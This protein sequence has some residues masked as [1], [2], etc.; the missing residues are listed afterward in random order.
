MK[1]SPMMQQYM[2]IKDA[3][4]DCILFFR[5]GDFY[6]MF[7]EDAILVSRLLDLTLTG[8]SCG[9]EDRAPM[10]GVPYHA[11][12][13]Y[14]GKLVDAGHRVAVCEQVEDPALAKGLVRREVVQVITPGTIPSGVMLNDGENNYLASLYS[15]D[16]GVGFSY[17]DISTGE[18]RTTFFEGGKNLETLIDEVARLGIRELLYPGAGNVSMELPE[19]ILNSVSCITPL[20]GH[21]YHHEKNASLLVEH[22]MCGSLTSL[23]LADMPEGVMASGALLQYLQETQKHGLPQMRSLTVYAPGGVMALD[24][25]TLRNLEI[26]EGLSDKRQQGT[27]LWVLD[28]THTAMGARKMKKWLR[29]PLNRVQLIRERLDAV[30]ELVNDPLRRNNLRE[31]LKAIY[32]FER[33]TARIATGTANGKDLIALRNSLYVL[34]DIKMDLM[35][36]WSMMLLDLQE[37]IHPLEGICEE[38]SAAIREDAPF[39]IREGGLINAGYSE[40]LDQLNESIREA[41]QWI[42]GLEGSERERTGISNLKVGYNKIFGYYLEITRSKYD[43]IPENYIR[44]Q[45]LVNAERFITPELKEMESIVLNAEVKIN[46]LEYAIFQELR[47]EIKCHID[48]IQETSDS[49]SS[50]DV[51]VAFA[52]TSSKFG[53]TK[54]E[55]HEGDEILIEKGRHPVIEQTI[56]DGIFVPNDAFINREESAMLLITGPNMAGKSTYMRQTALIVL[57]AQT[58]CFVPCEKARIGVVDRI[59]T[60]IGASDNLSQGQSTF[61]VEMSE[62]ALIL[63][64]ATGRS[65]ILLDEIGRGTSTYDGLSIAWSLIEYLC[66]P[67][68]QIRTLFATHYHELT[69]LEGS[70][71][72]FRNLNVDVS[73]E[74]GQVVFLHKIVPGSASKSYG[75]H[76]AQLAGVPES[77][78]E[79]ARLKLDILEKNQKNPETKEPGEQLDLF[80]FE[81]TL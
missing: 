50:L 12:E 25:S 47:E 42:A 58:G 80:T 45:T 56:R 36:C 38:I 15:G 8:K 67:E 43:M 13:T 24:K 74:N 79:N 27:L 64:N 75:I 53:Y 35:D 51:F 2:E 78:L 3:Y 73:D 72:G 70:L 41:R 69:A 66:A 7:F 10:C 14:I 29:S 28:R 71:P 37:K 30:D 81:E 63:G 76:V 21:Y 61:F 60:R 31:N 65:L 6:E 20:P 11:A 5:L 1:L 59:F 40:E 77:L 26:T 54:P 68:R 18:W 4:K 34:P 52:E 33:L 22:F 62:L 39:A 19:T 48:E 49:V 23:G 17:C 46:Q 44:K 16:Y 57:M 55:I 32:D 9:L